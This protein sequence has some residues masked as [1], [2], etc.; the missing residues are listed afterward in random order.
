MKKTPMQQVKD[1]FGD[2]QSLV[3]E[4]AKLV[5]RHHGDSSDSQVKSRLMGLSNAKL[6]RLYRV[7]QIVR[8]RYGDRSALESAIVDARVKA[9]LTAD[10]NFKKKLASY[11]K[12]QLVDMTNMR[13]GDKKIRQVA[14]S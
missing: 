9:G 14:S 7:E 2:R 6:L 10:D 5:D 11:S 1:N 12:A 4:L 13:V 3:N 8:E